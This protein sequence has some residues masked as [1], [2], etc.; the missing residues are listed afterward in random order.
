MAKRVWVISLFVL[1]ATL[2]RAAFISGH[3]RNAAPGTRVEML[4][5]QR[6][7]DGRD[8]YFRGELDVQLQFSIE[9]V[10]KEPQLVFLL[11]NDDRLAVFLSPGDTL[12]IRAD[13]FQ[14]PLAVQFSGPAGANNRLL[15]HYLRQNPLDFNEFNNI[16]FKIGQH[17]ASVEMPLNDLMEGL[18]PSQFKPYMDTL[19]AASVAL[20]EK[21]EL[22]HPGAL[23][24]DF[25]RWLQA[26][27]TYF[28]AYHLLVYGQ[29][30]AARHNIQ[31][32]FFD[33][34][35]E[36]S[37]MDDAI[38][39]AWYRQFLQVLLAR[40]QVKNQPDAGN[41]WAAQYQLAGKLLSGKPL[42]FF[43]SEVI[44]TAF[45]A[46]KYRE[47][48][49]LYTHFLQTNE[50]PAY[51]EKI[52]GLYQKFAPVLP[53]ATAPVFEAPD[54]NGQT[55]GLRQLRGKVVYLNFWASWCGACLRKME[56]MDAYEEE[57]VANGIEI[58]HVSM[59]ENA[60]SWQNTLTEQ[61]F[62][63]RHLLASSAVANIAQVYGVEAIPQYFII[64]RD[65]KFAEKAATSQPDD[66]RRK[67]LEIAQ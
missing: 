44:S 55:L 64:G 20:F 4:V 2:V 13:A 49:P 25:A 45:S 3:I 41:F 36:A 63:G 5:P 66:I 12:G 56:I 6:Y 50:Y 61:A 26:E 32:D 65:G 11:F 15:Q 47:L 48:L 38:G 52:E 22:Q 18:L 59:D 29:V 67:L 14:F 40:H 34:L 46:E 27:I 53:G 37:T 23:S 30:Y 42:A 51:D 35:Y 57:L 16:R 8:H 17:W 7:I 58:V 21:A 60:A 43:R 31:P 33:F 19:Q 28:R 24:P 39:S 10:V 9:L 54:V 1:S 62:R